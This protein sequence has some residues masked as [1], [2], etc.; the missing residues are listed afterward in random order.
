MVPWERP[1]SWV[2]VTVCVYT[3]ICIYVFTCTLN[4]GIIMK[5]CGGSPVL[6]IAERWC[7]IKEL[8]KER[9]SP[10]RVCRW[11][12][13]LSCYCSKVH[14]T[15]RGRPV[16]TRLA[17]GVFT[18]TKCFGKFDWSSRSTL[19]PLGLLPW[20][21]NCRCIRC[22]SVLGYRSHMSVLLKVVAKVTEV[23]SL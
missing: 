5:R 12:A 6:P 9:P 8:K 19:P 16:F 15:R 17:L 22:T 2:L 14:Y 23:A 11:A 20:V 10:P 21:G 4:V 1:P 13:F 18:F 7:F 3:F